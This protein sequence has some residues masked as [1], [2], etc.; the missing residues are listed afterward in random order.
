MSDQLENMDLSR[1]AL[2]ISHI[3]YSILF[4]DFDGNLLAGGDVS[5]QFDLTEGAL[6]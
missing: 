5:R 4:K 2:H 3:N 6:S 1:D